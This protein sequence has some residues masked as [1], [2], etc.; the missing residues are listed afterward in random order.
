MAKLCALNVLGALYERLGR[1]CGTS[2]EETVQILVKYMKSADSLVRI[3]IVQTFEKIL[4]GLG[5]AT[6]AAVHKDIFK[7]L[8]VLVQDR[9]LEVRYVSVKCLCEM[10]KHSTFLYSSSQ[11]AALS[12]S[13]STGQVSAMSVNSSASAVTIN[14]CVLTSAV[15][16]ELDASV[17][18]GFKA[19]D[20]SSNYDVR[21][22]VAAYL[23]QL[24]YYAISQLQKQQTQLHQQLQLANAA[25]SGNLFRACSDDLLTSY[26]YF[27]LRS[28]KSRTIRFI[29]SIALTF[30]LVHYST[31]YSHICTF[32][33]ILH[34]V[35]YSYITKV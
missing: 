29:Y 15:C 12:Q 23:A 18:L 8:K 10:M 28:L 4:F 6:G 35:S 3:E 19:L 27:D 5:T 30:K 22:G 1:M 20:T 14:G 31:I 32:V 33:F 17:Q 13:L 34:L 25:P 7:L 24:I 21:I 26:F 2:Y 16:A 11:M 9:V